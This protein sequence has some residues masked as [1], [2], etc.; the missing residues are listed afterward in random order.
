[1]LTFSDFPREG[2]G[3][4]YLRLVR[5]VRAGVASGAVRDG[6]ELPS[7]RVVSALLGVNPN[8]VQRAYRTLEE[9]GLVVSRSGA[10]SCVSV[11]PEA[12]AALRLRLQREELEK[13]VL[14]LR[15]SGMDRDEA[16]EL[17]GRL[18]DEAR[19]VEEGVTEE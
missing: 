8:T 11:T 15:R 9:E 12:L 3:P 2:E 17:F 7:R 18:W 1:M 4:V 14:A 19:E 13:T 16:L 10:K 5:Y 6:D